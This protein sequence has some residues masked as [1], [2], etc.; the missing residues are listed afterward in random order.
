MTAFSEAFDR[1]ALHAVRT[2]LLRAHAEA[3]G[4]VF[5]DLQPEVAP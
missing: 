4:F 2:E 5:A 1:V 3:D